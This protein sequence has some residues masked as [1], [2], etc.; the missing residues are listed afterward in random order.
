MT[1]KKKRTKKCP[2]CKG[3]G[4][5]PVNWVGQTKE[6]EARHMKKCKEVYGDFKDF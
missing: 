3:K 2:T 4:V 5:I 1:K 6:E